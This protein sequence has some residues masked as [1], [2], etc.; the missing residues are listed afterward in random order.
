MIPCDFSL[1]DSCG[2]SFVSDPEKWKMRVKN[3][4]IIIQ[5][6]KGLGCLI[7]HIAPSLFF[8]ENNY[9]RDSNLHFKMK[10][11]RGHRPFQMKEKPG[12]GR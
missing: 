5:A 4:D 10:E 3:V 9:E 8:K 11:N 7:I 2:L 1:P 12:T 6:F